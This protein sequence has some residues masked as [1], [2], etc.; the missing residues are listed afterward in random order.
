MNKIIEEQLKKVRVAD[1]SDYNPLDNEYHIPKM[2]QIRFSVNSCYI[3]RLK[4]NLL[5]SETSQVLSSNWNKGSI[6]PCK[7]LKIDVCKVLGKLI[8]VNGL[9]Y[10]EES[11][12]DLDV[13]WSGWL[14]I[15]DIEVLERI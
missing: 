14:P 12:K 10:D 9:G 13:I 2:N 15:Q 8:N 4:D 5:R 1:L 7:C 6:P 3:V 11:K